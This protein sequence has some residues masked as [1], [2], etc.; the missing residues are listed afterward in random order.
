MNSRLIFAVVAAMAMLAGCRQD[1]H[2]APRYEA[3]EAT[4]PF[5]ATPSLRMQTVGT[6]P[7]GW[8]REGGALQCGT[9]A[10]QL[11]NEFPFALAHAALV[12]GQRRFNVYCTACHGALGA[13]N[14]MVVQRGVR[15]AG[16]FLQDR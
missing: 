9:V 5:T 3:F 12:R 6:G 13:G 15:Q 14:G 16:S 11:I 4:A 8:L 7:R 2:D 10:G 1:M